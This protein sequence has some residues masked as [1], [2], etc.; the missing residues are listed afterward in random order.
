MTQA[1]GPGDSFVT[2]GLRLYWE[3]CAAV[4]SFHQQ[5]YRVCSDVLVEY[6]QDIKTVFG[7]TYT[8]DTLWRGADP[9]GIDDDSW[10]DEE[11]TLWVGIPMAHD[12]FLSIGVYWGRHDSGPWKAQAYA[13]LEPGSVAARDRVW[14]LVSGPGGSDMAKYGRE[15]YVQKMIDP[16]DEETLKRVLREVVQ[17]W[18]AVV[19]KVGGLQVLQ[20]A[21]VK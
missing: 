8:E 2:E 12:G 15:V 17:K 9:K 21:M 19:R 20:K 14:N 11:A 7:V 3:A 4:R 6:Q 16:A 10:D 18:L 5:V 1:M 13:T